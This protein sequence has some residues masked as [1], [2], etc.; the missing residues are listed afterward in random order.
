MTD[1]SGDLVELLVADHQR[2]LRL[3]EEGAEHATLVRE[4]SA[5]V[6]A[7]HQL[8]YP[9]VRR[10]VAGGDALVDALVG[11]DHRLEEALVDLEGA[12]AEGQARSAVE[13]LL[14]RHVS[15]Q[16]GV[17]AALRETATPEELRRL[18]DALGPT[19]MQAPT[20][21][22]PHLPEEGPLEVIADSLAA[23]LDQARDALRR[24]DE[25]RREG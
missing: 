12:D 23:S 21:P 15:E 17:F 22:H 6:V 5:H 2:M 8:L 11:V 14:A 16:H 4:V 19:L 24:R 25:D 13:S 10:R 9:L 3:I 1:A 18:G 20:H 7:E